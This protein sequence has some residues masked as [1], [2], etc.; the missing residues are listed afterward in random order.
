MAIARLGG[1]QHVDVSRRS[2]PRRRSQAR[3]STAS[4]LASTGRL[5]GASAA[6]PDTG[7]S[8]SPGS[9]CAKAAASSAPR[10]RT[11]GTILGG[12]RGI[13]ERFWGF[14]K[15]DG[16]RSAGSTRPGALTVTQLDW[17][18]T[19]SNAVYAPVVDRDP[20]SATLVRAGERAPPAAGADHSD[21]DGSLLDAGAREAHYHHAALIC[22]GGG[23]PFS[24]HASEVAARDEGACFRACEAES[25]RTRPPS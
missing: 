20:G 2:S 18:A 17:L 6:W 25:G 13:P 22:D 24:S 14:T 16:A 10:S 19:L 15:N 8:L 9:K 5:P 4:A 23:E 1:A 21:V 7:Q 3:S 12:D 11:P